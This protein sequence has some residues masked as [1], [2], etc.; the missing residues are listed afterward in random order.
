M[1]V[2]PPVHPDKEMDMSVVDNTADRL[3]DREEID[4]MTTHKQ[5]VSCCYNQSAGT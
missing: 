5:M 1:V 3:A 2:V 4:S